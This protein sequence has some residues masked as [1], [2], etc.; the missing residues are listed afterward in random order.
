MFFPYKI[1]K[2]NQKYDMMAFIKQFIQLEDMLI[3]NKF[4]LIFLCS[5]LK[6]LSLSLPHLWRHLWRL[7]RRLLGRFWP[8]K[9]HGNLQEMG[10]AAS[11]LIEIFPRDSHDFVFGDALAEAWI[12]WMAP[13]R[14]VGPVFTK[15]CNGDLKTA[16]P[17]W[18]RDESYWNILCACNVCKKTWNNW[19]NYIHSMRALNEIVKIQNWRSS[20]CFVSHVSC[21]IHSKGTPSQSW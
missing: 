20:R 12:C 1:K 9:T 10:I 15:G 18:I 2:I 3:S 19:R 8:S 5:L 11:H 17:I 4:I 21:V 14:N 6:Q 13:F 16:I 7:F